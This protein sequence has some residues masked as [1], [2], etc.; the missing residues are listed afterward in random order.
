MN[1]FCEISKPSMMPIGRPMTWAFISKPAR[2]TSATL[3]SNSRHSFGRCSRCSSEN[4]IGLP[5]PSA[6]RRRMPNSVSGSSK[7]EITCIQPAPT[8]RIA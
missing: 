6:T 8:P 5:E 4:V 1:G 3:S 7:S 2:F